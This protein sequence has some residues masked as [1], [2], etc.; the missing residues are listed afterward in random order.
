[1]LKITTIIRYWFLLFPVVWLTGAIPIYSIILFPLLFYFLN[2]IPKNKVVIC[3]I[4]FI[5]IQ[6]LSAALSFFGDFNDSIRFFAIIHNIYLFSL[7]VFGILLAMRLNITNVFS[8]KITSF[9][10]MIFSL[11]GSILFSYSAFFKK[12]EIFFRSVFDTVSLTRKDFLFDNMVPRLTLFGEYANSTA[13][14]AILLLVIY[15]FVRA[16]PG[17]IINSK[18]VFLSVLLIVIATGSRIAILSIVLMAPFIFFGESRKYLSKSLIFYLLISFLYLFLD[19]TGFLVGIKDLKSN[20]SNTRVDLYLNSLNVLLD[21]NPFT[22]LGLKPI[23]P[24]LSI[25]PLGSHSTYLGYIIKNGALGLIFVSLFLAWLASRLYIYGIRFGS[26]Y[27]YENNFKNY[28]LLTLISIIF[29]FEDIDAYA[30]N[31]LLF[32]III[33]ECLRNENHENTP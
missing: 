7:I 13:I 29:L 12:D 26:N 10:I 33:G 11:V 31:C 1:M 5:P 4:I 22:G 16:A 3:F 2:D 14:L 18:I 23:V 21:T 9:A 8:E 24:G 25:L 28:C 15:S 17:K 20:S 6:I 32:G 30:I 19:S 27:F